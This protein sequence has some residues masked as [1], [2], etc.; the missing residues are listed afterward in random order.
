[1]DRKSGQP[2]G[3]SLG[4]EKDHLLDLVSGEVMGPSTDHMLGQTLDL[5]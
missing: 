1:M 5:K 4:R 2:L 3:Q